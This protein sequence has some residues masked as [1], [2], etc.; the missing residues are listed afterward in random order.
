MRFVLPTFVVVLFAMVACA[1]SPTL[2]PVPTPVSSATLAPASTST[3]IPA[4]TLTP[5]VAPTSKPVQAASPTVSA[6][7]AVTPTLSPKSVV[8]VQAF[9]DFFRPQDITVTVGTQVTW[10][11]V[12]HKKHTVTNDTLFD[13]DLLVG[14]TFS[15]T[16]D[17][18]GFYQYYC[19]VHSESPTE[20]MVGTVT[21]VNP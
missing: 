11:N 8:R 14:Q 20:G 13:S 7:S 1:P 12:G 15:Y 16:F 9:D 5:A 6:A 10:F 4:A 3:Q 17:K 19:V 18:A 2:A 21:V